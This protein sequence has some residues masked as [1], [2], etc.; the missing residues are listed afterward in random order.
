MKK[1]ILLLFITVKLMF[2]NV[3]LCQFNFEKVKF[4]KIKDEVDYLKQLKKSEQDNKNSLIIVVYDNYIGEPSFQNFISSLNE[5]FKNDTFSNFI[6]QSFN[7]SFIKH[8]YHNE[9]W[10]QR[11]PFLFSLKQSFKIGHPI[12]YFVYLNS[13]GELIHKNYLSG[14][15]YKNNENNF[16]SSLI[17][18]LDTSTQ[19]YTL[20]KKFKQG[21]RDT[22]F[23]NS[24]FKI[25]RSSS[26]D[27]TDEYM[28][29]YIN[30]QENIYT[31]QHANVLMN[32]YSHNVALEHFYNNREKWLK[33]ISNKELEE[34]YK[35]QINNQVHDY[36]FFTD[37]FR[38]PDS[39]INLL[40]TKYPEY[41]R[42]IAILFLLRNQNNYEAFDGFIE[43]YLDN[44]LVKELSVIEMNTI[45]WYI[46]LY[47]T[48]RYSLYIALN[49][50]NKSLLHEQNPAYLDTYANLLYKLGQTKEAIE[51]ETKALELV[52]ASKKKSY[53][54]TLD[55]M[56]KGE[57]TW[58]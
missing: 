46:F 42:K 6:N 53:Q 48:N 29:D 43:K 34:Y 14:N 33:V 58:R 27:S 22:T 45:A 41:G 28:L 32:N 17:E 49:I 31:K 3:G 9:N 57:Q 40:E 51:I 8:K 15:I 36:F 20:I 56:K 24:F 19:C 35:R 10:N 38:K 16:R 7:C 37:Y 11:N 50:S 30:S 1:I 5:N 47:S 55:K 21:N 12:L 54:E 39:L 25:I 44:N 26:G 2:Q 18:A 13:K 52:D 4:H 23:I